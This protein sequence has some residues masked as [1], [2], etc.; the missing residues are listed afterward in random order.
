MAPQHRAARRA[1]PCLRRDRRE[2]LCLRAVAR[3]HLEEG[4]AADTVRAGA[5]ARRSARLVAEELLA[6]ALCGT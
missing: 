2:A 1:P 6:A 3:A 5:I 4:A